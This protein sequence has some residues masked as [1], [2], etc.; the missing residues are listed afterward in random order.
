MKNLSPGEEL[1][2]NAIQ[3]CID[4]G[5]RILAYEVQNARHYDSGN[6]LEY[7]KTIVDMGLQHPVIGKSFDEYI[8]NRINQ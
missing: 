8:R 2:Q 1:L 7:L 3:F 4:S 5:E 6:K